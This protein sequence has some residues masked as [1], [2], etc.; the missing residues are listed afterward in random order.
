MADEATQFDW[1]P[2]A[3]KVAIYAATVAL[4]ALLT[5]LGVPPQQV[6]R[7]VEVPVPIQTPPP[8]PFYGEGWSPDPDAVNAV[9]ATLP[10][11][12]FAA[13]PAGQGAD[14]LPPSAYLWQTHKKLTGLLPPV[15]N[16]NPLGSC[17]SFGTARAITRSLAGE[18][19]I[20]GG[21]FELKE[22]SEEPI[23]AGSRIEIGGGR[24][25]RGDGSVG[26]WAAKFVTTYGALP[27]AVFGRYDLTKYDPQRA[28][29]WGMPGYGVPDDLEADTKKFPA[30][31]ATQ[32]ASW[33]EAKRALANHYGI[34]ICSNV[35][36]N[37]PGTPRGYVDPATRDS[38][39]VCLPFGRWDHCMCLDGYH[40]DENGKE[41]G[42]IENSWSATAHQ[43]PV[44]WGEPNTSGFWT[45]AEVIDG[46]L[47]QGDSWAYSA[48]KGFPG[49]RLD[50]FVKKSRPL[51][52]AE[53]LFALA[54]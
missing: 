10:Q 2:L 8:A 19:A 31:S 33:A 50:W 29:Q 46:M 24:I 26:A 30:G 32:V 14:P 51:Q 13:T 4:T 17:V 23:Y 54:P 5:Y 22:V 49:K 43:G 15:H 53:T 21:N 42:H 9:L 35:G 6:E 47:K 38:R 16:Q 40:T 52:D 36:F 27:K 37:K 1:R 45:S 12:K 28:K 25:G 34:A 48:V 44:G 7:L 20:N 3:R 11:P 18:I 39:G 41:W